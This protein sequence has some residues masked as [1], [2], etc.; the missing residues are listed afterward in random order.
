MVVEEGHGRSG[1]SRSAPRSKECSSKHADGGDSIGSDGPVR[2]Q[3]RGGAGT[4]GAER[5]SSPTPGGGLTP[6]TAHNE[7]TD[8]EGVDLQTAPAIKGVRRLISQV[9]PDELATTH[10]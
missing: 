1:G 5:R 7:L 3:T 9:Q 2:N 4:R 10:V 6:G 8:D